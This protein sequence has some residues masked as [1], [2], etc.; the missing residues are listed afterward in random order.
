M[1][2]L[3]SSQTTT[4]TNTAPAY[5]GPDGSMQVILI[6]E[7]RRANLVTTPIPD[8]PDGG[9]LIRVLGCGLCGSDVEK[10]QHRPIQAPLVLGHEV[11]GVI[12]HL[13]PKAQGRFKHFYLGQ[14]VALAHHASCMQ[15]YYCTHQ[16]PSMCPEFKA[17]NLD[18]G[19]FCTYTAITEA[20]L[21]HTV[22]PVEPNISNAVAS[23]VE[24]L[25]CCLRAIDRLPLHTESVL[26]VGLGFIGQMT[27]QRLT[28]MGKTVIGIDLQQN[29]VEMAQELGWITQG[30]QDSDSL[31]LMIKQHTD[32]RG[33]DAVFL[34]AVTPKTLEMAQA[35]V[36][37]GGALMIF[38]APIPSPSSKIIPHLDPASVYFKEL[39]IL[40][41]YSPSMAH[42]GQAADLINRHQINLEPLITHC[43][44][45]P[46]IEQGLECYNSG[47]ALKVF[48][49]C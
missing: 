25:A 12:E 32:D 46:L 35:L 34:T 48:V 47:T 14:R 40:S 2:S 28:Q 10:W 17:S 33:V 7:Q 44:D 22:F 41:S 30:C 11:V 24:P 19:G 15:C 38:A 20:H 3:A 8:V 1:S 6:N 26:M 23:C 5:R 9:A 42:L 18:P 16:S 36:R 39:T 43:V 29:R 37:P 27:A 21:A 31:A 13:S 4:D 45:L 49:T